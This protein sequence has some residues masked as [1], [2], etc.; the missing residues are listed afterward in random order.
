LFGLPPVLTPLPPA[1]AL[2]ALAP[3]A[4]VPPV[5]GA[6]PEPAL[7]TA[8]SSDPPLAPASGLEPAMPA[9]TAP[10]PPV[11]V[12][13][14]APALPAEAPVWP[15]PGSPV[16]WPEQPASKARVE[17]RTTGVLAGKRGSRQAFIEAIG[18][19][20]G[21]FEFGIVWP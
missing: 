7:P 18:S 6:A 3:P 10:A 14:G 2:P 12:A 1:L 19:L 16:L 11:A 21:W 8:A 4:L 13:L 9:G 17:I 20:L 5:A 15:A